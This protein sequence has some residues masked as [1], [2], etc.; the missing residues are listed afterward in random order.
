MA[1]SAAFYDNRTLVLKAERQWRVRDRLKNK[2]PLMGLFILLTVALAAFGYFIYQAEGD[3]TRTDVIVAGA[4]VLYTGLTGA[5]FWVTFLANRPIVTLFTE[6]ERER[7]YLTIA[8]S[9]NRPA[10]DVTLSFPDPIMVDGRDLTQTT[11]IFKYPIGAIPAGGSITTGFGFGTAL[12]PNDRLE[13]QMVQTMADSAEDVGD[14]LSSSMSRTTLRAK[15]VVTYT[16]Q[17]SGRRYRHGIVLDAR[18]LEGLTW[19]TSSRE[20][21]LERNIRDSRNE[22]R[23]IRRL[24]QD[25]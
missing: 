11:G 6:R 13:A 18:Y 12:F 2:A 23:S 10:A 8:N 14:G 24:L 1:T 16:D 21:D 20:R 9:G 19:F 25:E 22:L 5:L 7:V 3:Y 15:G 17:I 4:T